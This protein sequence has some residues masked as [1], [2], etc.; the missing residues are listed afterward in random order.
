MLTNSW[1]VAKLYFLHYQFY[2]TTYSHSFCLRIGLFEVEHCTFTDEKFALNSIY[3]FVSIPF[4]FQ[5]PF[6][7]YESSLIFT[8][9]GF[10]TKMKTKQFFHLL[11]LHCSFSFFIF[12]LDSR[13]GYNSCL[14]IIIVECV[15]VINSKYSIERMRA[16]DLERHKLKS[17]SYIYQ[18]PYLGHNTLP[19]WASVTTSRKWD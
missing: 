2:K 6:T 5:T 15:N 1:C 17:Y 16:L 9:Y 8:L 7:F 11:F 19:L 12:K 13:N 10:Y 3:A 18:L 4:L 14:P